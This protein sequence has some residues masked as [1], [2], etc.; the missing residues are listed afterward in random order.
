MMKI[1]SFVD[2]KIITLFHLLYFQKRQTHGFNRNADCRRSYSSTHCKYSVFIGKS[3]NT[4]SGL[5]H[6]L[7]SLAKARST[8]FN[9]GHQYKA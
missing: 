8:E 9:L 6:P 1:I 2:L 3:L 5:G 4:I 7:Q